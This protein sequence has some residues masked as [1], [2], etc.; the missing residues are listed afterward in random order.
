MRSLFVVS[1][2][3]G[4]VTT[5]FFVVSARDG[6]TT[7]FLVVSVRG[8]VT[9][10]FLL[11]SARGRVTTVFFVESARRGRAVSGLVGTCASALLETLAEKIKAAPRM[12]ARTPDLVAVLDDAFRK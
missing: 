10:L 7:I 11:E 6:V 1:V 3:T 12:E 4:L 5:I 8:R 2:R 9:T